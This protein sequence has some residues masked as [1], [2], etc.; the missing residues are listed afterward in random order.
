MFKLII[1]LFFL[2][3]AQVFSE[4]STKHLSLRGGI[5]FGKSK[6]RSFESSDDMDGFGFNTHLN[7]RYKHT[8]ISLSSYIYWGSIEELAFKIAGEPIRGEGTFRSVS[9][10]PIIRRPFRSIQFWKHWSPYVALGPSWSIQTI[11]LKEFQTNL[12]EFNK[13]TKITYNSFG[14]VFAVGIEEFLPFKEMHS[15]YIEIGYNYSY[16]QKVSLIDF[17]DSQEVKSLYSLDDED[18]LHIHS[19][20]V[21]IGI[22]LF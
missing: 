15:V 9:F 1:I 13:E 2:F 18:D 16:S 21:S 20:L 17:S 22:V 3:P 6:I 11:K 19:L 5:T 7:Y 8:D 12:S 10:A 14:L 4:I